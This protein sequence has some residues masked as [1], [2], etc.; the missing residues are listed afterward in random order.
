[1]PGGT[2]WPVPQ[3]LGAMAYSTKRRAGRISAAADPVL[4]W[5]SSPKKLATRE[6]GTNARGHRAHR[7]V[8]VAA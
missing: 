3:R 7:D 4:A 1:M 5:L 6:F 2:I 8:V